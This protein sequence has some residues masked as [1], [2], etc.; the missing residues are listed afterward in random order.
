VKDHQAKFPVAAM[1]RVLR[2]S[3]SGFY[4]WTKRPLSVH[5]RRDRDL[6]V[7]VRTS[8]ALSD[9]TYGAPRILADLREA[10]EHVSQKR[11]AR[12]MR[13]LDLTGV[14]RRRRV[15]R[16]TIR[17]ADHTRA[18]PSD[19]VERNFAADAPNKLWVADITYVPTWLGFLY[20]AVVLDAFSR[21]VVGWAMAT[22]LKT[23]L[24][25]DALEMAVRQ[26]HPAADAGSSGVIHHSDHGCQYTSV[27]FGKRCDEMN[28]RPSMGAVGDAYDN[29][30]AESFFATL[31]C[32]LL[33]R[34]IFKTQMEARNAIFRFIEGWY[35]PRRR[36]SALGYRSPVEFE[37]LA[38]KNVA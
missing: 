2:I 14:S 37:R 3:R 11:I 18:T 38:A 26:R 19:L 12:L 28:V 25:L 7:Q 20:L 30:M 15:I 10:G 6:A 22:H 17:S 32:E 36:H 35:N 9:G 34:R 31:E 24:V 8:H 23:E 29:A 33:D 16:T 4:A 21:R 1:C 13:S 5:A 27:A